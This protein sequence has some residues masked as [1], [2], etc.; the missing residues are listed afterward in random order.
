MPGQLGQPA[1]SLPAEGERALAAYAFLDFKGVDTR[2][3]RTAIPKDHFYNLENLQPIGSS[4]LHT[5]L[6]ISAS[7]HDF[8]TDVIYFAQSAQVVLLSYLFDFASN[9]KIITYRLDTGATATINPSALLSGAGSRMAQ[10]MNTYAL[11]ADSTGYYYWDGTTFA[12]LSGGAF[13]ASG[14]DIVVFAGRVWISQ[15]RLILFSAANDGTSTTDPTQVTA[16]QTANGAGFL[17]M[18][19]PTLVGSITR[20][21]Q[22]NGYLYIIGATCIY[23][24][25]DVYVPTDAT[26]PTPVFTLLNVQGIIGTDQPFSVFSYNRFVMFAN[27]FGAWALD[28]V[29]AQRLSKDI[30]GTWQYLSFNPQVSGGQCVSNNILCAAFLLQRANDPVFGSDT[31]LGMW[32]DGAWWFANFGTLTFVTSAIVN[33]I[34]VL[35]GFIG[36]KL[37]SMFTSSAT[38]PTGIAMTALWDM[39]DP[40]SDKA[41]IRAGVSAVL[42]AFAGSVGVTVDGTSGPVAMPVQGPGTLTFVNN[43][44][45]PLQFTGAGGANITWTVSTTILYNASAPGTWSRYIGLTFTTTNVNCQVQGFFMDYK[46]AARWRSAQGTG[47]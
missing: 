25:S 37:Y 38:V 15:G 4:N 3:D 41:V 24:L 2:S 32:A 45:V 35:F 7:L 12:L 42:F 8:A 23:A 16:W 17:N 14:T 13:P 26:P 6:N 39:D 5:V 36:N 31:V 30:D 44:N 18:T 1:Q 43:S 9:G 34:P 19:D 11:F 47:G 20:L 21:W 28:G 10:W 33:S 29:N 27:K 46:K 22:Q 40:L